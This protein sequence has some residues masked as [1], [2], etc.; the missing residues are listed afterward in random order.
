MPIIVSSLAVTTALGGLT[1][2]LAS[3]QTPLQDVGQHLQLTTYM[4]FQN[5]VS[6]TGGKW[7][8]DKEATLLAYMRKRTGGKH[9]STK[10]TATGGRTVTAK[11]MVALGGK[12]ILRNTGT[13]QDLMAYKITGNT[14]IFGPS[15]QTKN[16]AAAMQYGVPQKNIPARPYL[17]ITPGDKVYINKVFSN[18]LVNAWLSK[19]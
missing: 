16:Y 13:L 10:K 3:Y 17:G 18:Y 12:K 19:P 7:A 2:A 14:L 9:L 1:K 5:E 15:V 4:R 11:G 8:P 6:P